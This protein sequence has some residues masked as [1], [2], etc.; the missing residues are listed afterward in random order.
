M[1]GKFGICHGLFVKNSMN[2]WECR[3]L[4][5]VGGAF[6][7]LW[8]L[9]IRKTS[10]NGF[11]PLLSCHRRWSDLR[12]GGG[13][14]K[15][16]VVTGSRPLLCFKWCAMGWDQ[17]RLDDDSN[18][19]LPSDLVFWSNMGNIH[20]PVKM[21]LRESHLKTFLNSGIRCHERAR[22]ICCQVFKKKSGD[23]LRYLRNSAK[24]PNGPGRIWTAGEAENAFRKK[25]TAEGGGFG[26]HGKVG[27]PNGVI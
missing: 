19:N 26:V 9:H 22:K 1:E 16:W 20:S 21:T 24:D 15:R 5:T 4:Y 8:A 2:S 25:R 18:R 17:I 3:Y 11:G 7:F 12:F 14:W 27:V 10:P 13:K 23:F 6:F